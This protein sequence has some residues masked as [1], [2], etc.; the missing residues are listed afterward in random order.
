MNKYLITS[1]TRELQFTNDKKDA[2]KVGTFIAYA[3]SEIEARKFAQSYGEAE[4]KVHSDT[5]LNTNLSECHLLASE[6]NIPTTQ[7]VVKEYCS[8]SPIFR[9]GSD[10]KLVIN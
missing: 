9:L 2:T 6:V 10:N 7:I 4:L 3:P 1:K 8:A 5:W